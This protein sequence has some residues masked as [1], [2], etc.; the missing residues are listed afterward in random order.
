MSASVEGR[1]FVVSVEPHLDR[2]RNWFSRQRENFS[3]SSATGATPLDRLRNTLMQSRESAVTTV[4]VTGHAEEVL[5]AAAQLSGEPEGSRSLVGIDLVAVGT[6]FG[7]LRKIIEGLP[8]FSGRIEP[9]RKTHTVFVPLTTDTA[10]WK[11]MRV[12]AMGKGRSERRVDQLVQTLLG[13]A[14]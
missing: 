3:V 8:G 13:A 10:D 1:R 4:F 7:K 6:R 14:V 5:T 2:A 9:D 11:Y 12:I